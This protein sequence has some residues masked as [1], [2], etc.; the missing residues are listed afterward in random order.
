[1]KTYKIG[2]VGAGNVTRMHLKGYM[3]H[4]DRVEVVAICDPN[5]DT[6][7]ERAD[8][9]GIPSRYS[10]PEDMIRS[11]E[12]DAAVV[13]TPSPIRK[14][15]LFPLIE[16]GIPVFVEKPFS[17]TLAEATDIAEKAKKHNVPVCV[18]QNFRRHHRFEFIRNLVKENTI[19][20]A[21]GIHFSSLHFR[22][23]RAH[24]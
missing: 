16:A 23:G 11:A 18:N 1:M 12:I 22:I 4:K 3:N 8:E 13:C 19:G 10:N 20:K 5:P 17:D 7:R 9:F 24:V 2:I 21:Q 6:V 15:V 14:S